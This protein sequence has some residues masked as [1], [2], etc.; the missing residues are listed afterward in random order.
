MMKEILTRFVESEFWIVL[1]LLQ[2]KNK[3]NTRQ[4]QIKQTKSLNEL[5]YLIPVTL[6]SV[7]SSVL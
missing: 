2:I 5:M 7:S 6:D 3:E 1:F 4:Y